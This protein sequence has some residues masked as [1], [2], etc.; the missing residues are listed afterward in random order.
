MTKRLRPVILAT[1]AALAV[2]AVGTILPIWTVMTRSTV[3]EF[4]TVRVRID[5][6]RGPLWTMTAPAT[7]QGSFRQRNTLLGAGVAGVAIGVGLLV[8]RAA[9]LRRPSDPVR[10]YEEKPDG[11]IPDGRA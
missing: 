3:S 5:Y 11:S 9:T 4:D 8:H 6:R 1:A 10:D 7:E 2:L